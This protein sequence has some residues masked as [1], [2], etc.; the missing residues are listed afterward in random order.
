MPYF[1][2]T[3]ELSSFNIGTAI[4]SIEKIYE[5]VIDE[6]GIWVDFE[7]GLF[8][9]IQKSQLIFRSNMTG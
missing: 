1:V 6:W 7:V 5:P 8:E 4:P 9:Q 2:E 3:L